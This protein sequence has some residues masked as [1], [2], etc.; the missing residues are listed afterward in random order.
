[1]KLLFK[2]CIWLASLVTKHAVDAQAGEGPAPAS[3]QAVSDTSDL[4]QV[5]PIR[6]LTAED[7]QVLREKFAIPEY[8]PGANIDQWITHSA[9]QGMIRFLENHYRI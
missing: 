6:G 4:P 7:I 9:Y 5:L 2:L 8:K 1:M 3:T